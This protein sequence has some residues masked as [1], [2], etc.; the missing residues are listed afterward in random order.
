MMIVL[1]ESILLSLGGGLVGWIVGHAL[2][3]A[4]APTITEYTGVAVSFVQFATGS[5][6]ILIPALIVLGFASRV[7]AGACGLSYRCRQIIDR[8]TVTRLLSLYACCAASFEIFT[9]P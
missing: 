8:H 1:A 2:V 4:A 7:L 6:V 3:G 9:R 5:E